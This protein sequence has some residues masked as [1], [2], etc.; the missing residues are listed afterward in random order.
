VNW[1]AY[2]FWR[3]LIRSRLSD[4][5]YYWLLDRLTGNDGWRPLRMRY[6]EEFGE[7]R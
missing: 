2:K 7:K 5:A 6:P 4:S 1:L 3:A